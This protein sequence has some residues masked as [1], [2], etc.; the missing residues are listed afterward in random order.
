MAPKMPPTTS[1][2]TP[3]PPTTRPSTRWSTAVVRSRSGCSRSF[4]HGRRHGSGDGRRQERGAA[5]AGK[6]TVSRRFFSPS[7]RVSVFSTWPRPADSNANVCGPGSTPMERP[8]MR[9]TSGAPSIVTVTSLTSS[10]F[11][12]FTS[13]KMSVGWT[14][15]EMVQP[16]GAVVADDRRARRRRAAEE[17]DP[18]CRQLPVVKEILVALPL[19]SM[20]W[21]LVRSARAGA[22]TRHATRPGPPTRRAQDVRAPS[23]TYSFLKV[24]GCP[25][26]DVVGRVAVGLRRQAPPGRRRAPRRRRCRRGLGGRGAQP[27]AESATVALGRVGRGLELHGRRRWRQRRVAAAAAAPPGAGAAGLEG[28]L[29][30]TT[31]TTAMATSMIAETATM[32][33]TERGLGFEPVCPQEAVGWSGPAPT[34]RC[35]RSA[36]PRQ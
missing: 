11:E 2:A 1:P 7:R 31:A 30:R 27:G 15:V 9:A 36:G 17:L 25:G 19:A 35:H 20:H 34:G 16:L 3:A 12:S 29:T 33:V 28:L 22:A 6:T 13:K 18:R 21:T 23:Q 14:L 32:A 5:G 26:V 8:T 10:P 4:G 24:C